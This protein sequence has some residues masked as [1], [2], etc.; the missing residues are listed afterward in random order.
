MISFIIAGSFKDRENYIRN[1]ISEN[2]YFDYEIE[3]FEGKINVEI[4]R[5]IKKSLTFKVK[6]KK[7]IVLSGE[8]SIEAQNS[9]LKSIEEPPENTVFILSVEKTEDLLETIRS[10]CQIINLNSITPPVGNEFLENIR[11]LVSGQKNEWLVIDDI[12]EKVET[13]D[14]VNLVITSI[15]QLLLENTNKK[16]GRLYFSYLKKLLKNLPLYEKNNI[17][18]R[19]ILEKSFL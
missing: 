15:R 4:A 5:N 7:L 14:D 18:L 19:I 6:T 2:H 16:E 17:Q 12:L 13:K 3:R 8:F 1:F 10:R 9:L 11:L